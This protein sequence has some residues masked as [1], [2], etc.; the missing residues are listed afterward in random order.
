MAH[1]GGPFSFPFVT[2]RFGRTNNTYNLVVYLPP[3]PGDSDREKINLDVKVIGGLLIGL[4]FNRG[5]SSQRTLPIIGLPLTSTFDPDVRPRLGHMPAEFVVH[6]N[7]LDTLA[8]LGVPRKFY[9]FPSGPGVE[10]VLED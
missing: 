5:Y 10:L 8:S 9:P 1:W 2:W 6:R 7:G 4:G 3:V